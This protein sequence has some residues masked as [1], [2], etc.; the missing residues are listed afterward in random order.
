MSLQN[1]LR[2]RKELEAVVRIG[3]NLES[4]YRRRV[5]E[6]QERLDELLRDRDHAKERLFA[7]DHEYQ[8]A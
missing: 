2:D 8:G 1:D 7:L 6:A 3:N 5:R 4:L